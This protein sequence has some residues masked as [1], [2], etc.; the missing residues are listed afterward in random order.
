MYL[1]SLQIAFFI[2]VFFIINCFGQTSSP[3]NVENEKWTRIETAAQELTLAFPPNYIVDAEEKKFGR[4]YKI[5]GFSND[6][7]MELAVSKNTSNRELSYIKPPKGMSSAT[8]VKKDLKGIRTSSSSSETSLKE[9]ISIAGDKNFYYISITAS[10][11]T[12]PEI[13]R[14][15]YSIKMKGENLF[16]NPNAQNYPESSIALS[17]LKTSSEVT[18]ALNRKLEKK[19]LKAEKI[20]SSS[21]DQVTS[22]AEYS[23]P[24]IIVEQ[25]YPEFRPLFNGSGSNISLMAKLKLTLLADGQIG[26]ITVI[27]GSNDSYIDSCV[28]SVRKLRFVPAQKNGV[29]ADSVKTIE[30]AMEAFTTGPYILPG[31]VVTI[32]AP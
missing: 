15:L 10:D 16:K 14:F 26:S 11:K 20:I 31:N 21:A 17:S 3:P 25:P 29:N 27:A 23:R 19:K 12:K 9:T 28:D 1:K 4:I 30:F 32:P 5:T 6:V 8:F 7:T 22:Y 13:Q 18:E 24:P 2:T